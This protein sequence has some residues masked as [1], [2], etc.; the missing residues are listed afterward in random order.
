MLGQIHVTQ[1]NTQHEAYITKRNVIFAASSF[2]V[3]N[4]YGRSIVNIAF[5]LC[6]HRFPRRAAA[7]KMGC[8]FHVKCSCRMPFIHFGEEKVFVVFKEIP[9]L[10]L[11]KQPFTHFIQSSWT[12]FHTKHICRCR[13]FLYKYAPYQSQIFSYFRHCLFQFV[14]PSVMAIARQL[15][16]SLYFMKYLGAPPYK[17]YQ[18]NHG[19]DNNNN[20]SGKIFLYEVIQ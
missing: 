19:Y 16:Y 17:E 18:A 5:Y 14:H 3:R 8:I 10:Y 20:R 4:T 9:A 11:V 1:W 6:E 7:C 2:R 15:F 13:I 12:F